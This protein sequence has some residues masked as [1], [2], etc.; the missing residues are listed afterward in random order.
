MISYI[1]IKR[2]KTRK[3]DEEESA[4]IVAAAVLVGTE[5]TRQEHIDRRQPR[6][7]YLC[8]AQL[9]PNPWMSTPWQALFA[10]QNDRAFITTMGFDME[11]FVFILTS[12]FAKHWYHTP[13]PRDNISQ[14]ANP[15]V[16]H[17]SLDAGG[18]LGLV[19]HYLNSTMHQISLQQIFALILTTVS[20]YLSLACAYSSSL[21][22]TWLMAQDPLVAWRR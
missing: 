13:I 6:R 17:R 10:S 22:A 8:R 11:T 9:L 14:Y 5:L 21:C 4:L 20:R 18:D 7:L 2:Y 12:G 19:L 1:S 15:R 16:E 3:I